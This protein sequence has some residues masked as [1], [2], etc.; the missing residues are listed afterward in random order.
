MIFFLPKPRW[1]GRGRNEEALHRVKAQGNGLHT[2]KNG[3][4]T[5]LVTSC[6]VTTFKNI[7]G[8]I[9]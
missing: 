5:G 9:G 4:L 7:E 3:R 8:K 1:T 2:I 6:V